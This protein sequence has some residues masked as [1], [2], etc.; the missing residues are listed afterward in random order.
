[1]QGIEQAAEAL[2]LSLQATSG[3]VQIFTREELV[4]ARADT[5]AVDKMFVDTQ[6]GCS[7]DSRSCRPIAVRSPLRDA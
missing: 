6:S 4:K 7:A 2:Q 1:V 3:H 5:A